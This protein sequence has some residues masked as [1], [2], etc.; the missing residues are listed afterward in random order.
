MGKL[1]RTILIAQKLHLRYPEF[2][3]P[4][5]ISHYSATAHSSEADHT[6]RP[7]NETATTGWSSYGNIYDRPIAQQGDHSDG[8]ENPSG[9]RGSDVAVVK[10][11]GKVKAQWVCSD[12]GHTTGKWWGTC[13]ECE[14]T[15]TMQE[16]HESKLTDKSRGGLAI[17][18]DAVG[19]WLPRRPEEL[20]PVK[21]EEVNRGFNHDKW[22]IPLSGSLG[23]EVSTVLGGGLVPGS[24]TL[25]GG[26][27][28]IGKSTLLLQISAMIANEC[29]DG[30]TPPVVYVSG[31]ESLKQICARADRL[32]IK[33]NIYLYSSTDIEDILR[34]THGLSPCALVVDS[35]QTAYLNTVIGSAGGITQVKE[36]T[37]ALMRFAKTTNIS[38]ILIGHVTK[39][40]EIAGPRVLEHIV[41]VVLYME[42]E[43]YSPYRMLRAVKNRFGSTD[44]LAVL[45][46]SQSGLQVVSNASEMFLTQ[47]HSDSNVLAGLAIAVIMDGTRTFLVEIQALCLT[48]SPVSSS[49]SNGIHVNRANIIKCVL[50]K[51]AG[52]HLQ[53]NA[54]FLNVVGGFKVTETAGDLAIAAAMC[55]SFLEFP[56]PDGT[57]FIGEIGLS[58]E[59]RMVPRIDKRVNT[60]AKLGY[61]MC[62]VPKQAEKLL[63]TEGLEEMKVVGCKDLK[64]VINTVF[65]RVI[66]N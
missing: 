26:D 21:L 4:P 59:L 34:K 65:S 43:K 27:P 2:I 42:G 57:A 31:E 5:L 38:V 19:S 14:L 9:L 39:S 11:K 52:L 45:E 64:E 61:R 37:A 46:M 60:V 56:I 28:G 44:E 6:H 63:E 10:K 54:V 17:T 50:I 29:S 25:V 58:G 49:Q 48:H 8:D 41:D 15:G 62:V 16:F 30:E 51:Q 35:I 36:C 40:G 22:R 55:S 24:L 23:N 18:E 53:D 12:C 33:S 20:R 13:P 47:Q 7:T 66:V 32:G 3:F 1:L